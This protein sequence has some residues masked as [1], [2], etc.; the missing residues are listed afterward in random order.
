MTSAR[1]RLAAKMAGFKD[2]VEKSLEAAQTTPAE[3]E[4]APPRVGALRPIWDRDRIRDLERELVQ[5]RTRIQELE[6]AEQKV[7]GAAPTDRRTAEAL[8]DARA[9]AEAAEREI[10]RLLASGTVIDVA[11][12]DIVESP[13]QPRLAYDPTELQGLA[14]SLASQGQKT[15]LVVRRRADG[16]LELLEGHRRKR[17]A[18]IA[19]LTSLRALVVDLNDDEAFLTVTTAANVVASTTEYEKARTFEAALRR[20]PKLTQVEVAKLYGCHKSHV[21]NCLALL[22]LPS[23]VLALLDATPGLFGT[24]RAREVR[25]LLTAH[26]GQEKLIVEALGRLVATPKLSLTGYVQG[27]IRET[28]ANDAKRGARGRVVK[29]RSGRAL[30]SLLV[31]NRVATVRLEKNI[32]EKAFAEAVVEAFAKIELKST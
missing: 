6:Q 5:A 17:A 3:A 2:R 4:N 20:N 25:A 22:T 9:R 30:G 15:H 29:D 7:T 28:S 8:A 27:K 1:D 12:G 21:S 11:L 18:A 23:P 14:D 13:F 19:G 32:D 31:K 26:P 16:K 24:D 10:A